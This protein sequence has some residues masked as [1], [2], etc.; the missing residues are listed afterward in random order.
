MTQL[1]LPQI[2]FARYVDLLK[3]RKW[4][5]VPVSLLGMIVG[6]VIAASVPRYYV[7]ST[8]VHF[9]AGELLT[10]GGKPLVEILEEELDNA[11]TMI[12]AQ[13]PDLL[14]TFDW[15]EAHV[16]DFDARNEFIA[17]VTRGCRCRTSAT[18]A[19]TARSPRCASATATPTAS[20]R[21]S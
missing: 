9:K 13:V 2:S 20:G 1:D 14:A 5:V 15:P 10:E 17:A 3:R 16:D 12:P 7:A 8:D 4:Q 21:R 19:A 11:R 6:G 18:T